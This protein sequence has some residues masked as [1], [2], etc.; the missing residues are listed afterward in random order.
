M[1]K[2]LRDLPVR[3]WGFSLEGK[4]LFVITTRDE[5]NRLGE[6]LKALSD[7]R[8]LERGRHLIFSGP[9]SSCVQ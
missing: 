9:V 3:A 8:D 7:L 5:T 4:V 6:D 2:R 1:G